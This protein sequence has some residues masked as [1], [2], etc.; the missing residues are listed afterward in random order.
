MCVT[1]AIA[2]RFGCVGSAFGRWVAIRFAMRLGCGRIAFRIAFRIALAVAPAR[3]GGLPGG[4]LAVL[5]WP[6]PLV[7][8]V[9]PVGVAVLFPQADLD[10]PAGEL[11]GG[12]PVRETGH[13]RLGDD[14]L[15]V[16]ALHVGES[17]E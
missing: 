11:R 8:V 7:V 10:Q 13:L 5:P 2:M 3:L 15:G 14:P 12:L 16:V 4:R 17:A 1:D 6:V 9:D